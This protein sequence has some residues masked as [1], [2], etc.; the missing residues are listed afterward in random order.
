MY[1]VSIPMLSIIRFTLVPLFF[2]N[3]LL[4]PKNTHK[5]HVLLYNTLIFS[6]EIQLVNVLKNIHPHT[7]MLHTRQ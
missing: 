7:G 4:S 3:Q 6:Q 2:M 5:C 1:E